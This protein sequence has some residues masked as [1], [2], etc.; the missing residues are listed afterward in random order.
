MEQVPIKHESL[1]DFGT[2]FQYQLS[3]ILMTDKKYFE[4]IFDIFDYSAFDS[5]AIK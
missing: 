2:T 4:Q 5:S 1:K 3:Y